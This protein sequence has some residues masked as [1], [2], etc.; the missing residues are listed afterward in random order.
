MSE[1]DSDSVLGLIVVQGEGSQGVCP[2][3]CISS[4]LPEGQRYEDI[5]HDFVPSCR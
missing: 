5:S 1:L 3:K 4:N 2:R